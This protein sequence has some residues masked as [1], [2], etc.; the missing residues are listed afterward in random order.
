MKNKNKIHFHECRFK[1]HSTRVYT[2]LVLRNLCCLVVRDS[3][4]CGSMGPISGYYFGGG[5]NVFSSENSTYYSEL[6][7]CTVTVLT[8]TVRGR[9]IAQVVSRWIHI[10]VAWFR[11]TSQAT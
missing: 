3:K 11:A 8:R 4:F 2:T 9:A 1:H 10:A 5:V 6:H 7:I